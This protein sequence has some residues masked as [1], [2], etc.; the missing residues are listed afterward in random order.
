MKQI[1]K[2]TI[3]HIMGDKQMSESQDTQSRSKDASKIS[4]SSQPRYQKPQILLVD[5]DSKVEA[6]LKAEGYT[7][8]SGSFGAP[9]KVKKS[10]NRVPIIVEAN[11]PNY[12]EQEI[13]IVDLI[14]HKILD[15]PKGEKQT[16]EGTNDWW[17]TC[18]QG[19][20]DPR[21]RSMAAVQDS[22][23]NILKHGGVFIIFAASRYMQDIKYAHY[24]MT[25]RELIPVSDIDY[26]NWSFLSVLSAGY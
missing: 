3:N 26:D 2:R 11:L 8:E 5:M 19:I 17:V 1:I 6:A 13:V 7:V 23:D 10:D 16:S 14:A 15:E 21:P 22:F 18:N 24:S 4:T 25:Y 9:Y 20:V 12:T